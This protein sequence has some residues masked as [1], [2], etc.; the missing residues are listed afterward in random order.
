MRL[1]RDV[2]L[3]IDL[4]LLVALAIC[5]LSSLLVFFL[6]ILRST[7]GLLTISLLATAG[8]Y[9]RAA[10]A[11]LFINLVVFAFIAGFGWLSIR[12][13]ILQRNRWRWACVAMLVLAIVFLA[14]RFYELDTRTL[15]LFGLNLSFALN[16]WAFLRLITLLWEFGS[17]RI[18]QPSFASFILWVGLPF[19]LIGPILRYSQFENQRHKSQTTGETSRR[20]AP[21]TRKVLLGLLQVT[22]G[23]LLASV[24]TALVALS[25]DSLPR[26]ERVAIAFSLAPWSFYLLWAGYFGLMEALAAAW[27]LDLPPSF[28]RPFG[29]R[30]LSEFWANWNMTATSV[31]R[32]YFFFNRWGFAKANLYL[33]SL[34]VFLMVGLWHGLNGYWVLWGLLHGIGFCAF[35]WYTNNKNRFALLRHRF[36]D[37]SLNLVAPAA[38]YVYVC[39]CWFVPPTILKLIR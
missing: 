20:A 30:N 36:V 13:A 19:T 38:T 9:R 37:S 34:I 11:Y 28:N 18:N 5:V 24:Q 33:N 23:L 4:S 3:Q 12:A 6:P 7:F 32:D 25:G 15:G 27:Q 31:F 29:R 10:F 14:V 2:F 21:Q 8:I 22:L 16:M 17:G 35:L 39:S 26:W 1:L